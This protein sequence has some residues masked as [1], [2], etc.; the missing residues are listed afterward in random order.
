MT[1]IRTDCSIRPQQALLLLLLAAPACSSTTEPLPAVSLLVT[2]TT[3]DMGHCTPLQILGFPSNQPHTPGG[4]WS[5]DLGI[6]TGPTGCLSLPPSGTFRVTDASTGAT[7]TYTWTVSD[8][9]ALGAETD[10]DERLR[11]QPST[12]PFV[13]ATAAGWSIAFPGGIGQVTKA[14]AC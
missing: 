1:R 6:V 5:I 3:C 9:L 8:P 10:P 4:L 7:T 11:A 2:N 14:A 12:S 13:P